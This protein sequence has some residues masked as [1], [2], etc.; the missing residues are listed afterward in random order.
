[1]GT[2]PVSV[3]KHTATARF[4]IEVTLVIGLAVTSANLFWIIM[5]P[6]T[7][8]TAPSAVPAIS[9]SIGAPPAA[10]SKIDKA[11]LRE[12]NPFAAQEAT[13]II[14]EE[15]IDA[16]ETSL[17]LTL[18]G[19]RAL[20][21][22]EGVAFILLP[23]NQQVRVGVGDALLDN[24]TVERVYPDRVTLRTNGQLESL[25]YREQG[26]ARS[27]ISRIVSSPQQTAENSPNKTPGQVSARELLANISLSSVRENGRRTGYRLTP[28]GEGR[29]MQ[30]AGFLSGDII[31]A[32]NAQPI[33]ELSGEDLQDLFLTASYVDLRIERDDQFLNVSITFKEG[34]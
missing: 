33:L 21:N 6:G 13:P 1:M 22:G 7:G 3:E 17:N 27:G 20:G 29:V 5:T 14:D 32:V 12:Y 24:V 31:R 19:L 4:L 9:V 30:S 8:N 18:K 11:I 23:D 10:S 16:P 26:E 34:G 2:K 28:I 15:A 25:H